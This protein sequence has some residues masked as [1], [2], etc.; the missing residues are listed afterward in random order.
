MSLLL[1]APA[2]VHY[3][4]SSACQPPSAGLWLQ[5]RGYWPPPTMLCLLKLAKTLEECSKTIQ[6]ERIYFLWLKLLLD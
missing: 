5:P 1:S 4:S 2:D 3:K 6:C